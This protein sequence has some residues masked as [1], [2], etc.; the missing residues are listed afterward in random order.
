MEQQSCKIENLQ[1]KNLFLLEENMQL[2]RSM[3]GIERSAAHII[4]KDLITSKLCIFMYISFYKFKINQKLRHIS[5]TQEDGGCEHS[6]HIL[7][8]DFTGTLNLPITVHVILMLK[9]E[10]CVVSPI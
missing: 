1:E 7:N 9:G 8:F 6:E 4:Y 10:M 2:K 3:E 5:G